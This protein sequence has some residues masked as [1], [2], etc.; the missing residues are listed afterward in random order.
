[1]TADHQA[2]FLA[3]EKFI[4]GN[5]FFRL[6]PGG[7]SVPMMLVAAAA[8]AFLLYLLIPAWIRSN[9]S[10]PA[11]RDAILGATLTFTLV[12][13]PHAQH[14]DAVLLVAALLLSAQSLAG[15]Q[16][17][18][19]RTA[20]FRMCLVLWCLTWVSQTVTRESHIQVLSLAIALLGLLQLATAPRLAVHGTQQTVAKVPERSDERIGRF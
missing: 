4:D 10:G 19:L 3:W 2:A 6:L 13:T 11:Y 7:G 14:Y 15:S 8:G 18:R 17:A 5:H 20:Y 9:S 12:L 16:D 1:M